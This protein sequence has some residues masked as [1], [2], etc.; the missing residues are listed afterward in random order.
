M[1]NVVALPEE[2]QRQPSTALTPLDMLNAAVSRGADL[3]MLEKL[4]GL[5]ERWEAT[6]ARKAFDAAI[7]AAKAKIP[8]VGRNAT[9]HNDRKY[10]DFAAIARTVDPILAEHGLS[11]RFRT[12]QDERIHVTC[13]L[14][15]RDGHSEET[16][17]AGPAD[18]SGSKNAIQAIGSTLQYLM[19]YSLV[20][21]LGLATANDDD[22]QAAGAGETI[23]D[24]QAKKIRDEI[25]AVDADETA[26]LKYLGIETVEA[27]P[28]AQFARAMVALGKKRSG[29]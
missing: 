16:T 9:G 4:M 10:A 15:H 17:L 18:N 3:P 6:N 12:K 20:Q 21:M 14:S 1:T 7:S 27:L 26:F 19:R 5:H 29:K 22:G 11:Y 23:S 13:I 8:P 2:P 28:A 24:E 25:K